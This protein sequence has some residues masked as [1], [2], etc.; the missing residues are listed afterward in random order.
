MSLLQTALDVVNSKIALLETQK[1]KV[2]GLRN[3]VASETDQ[4]HHMMRRY[5]QRIQEKQD[6]LDRYTVYFLPLS[7]T[8]KS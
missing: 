2:I 7:R 6:E 1:A 8:R 5:K 4:R 3:K